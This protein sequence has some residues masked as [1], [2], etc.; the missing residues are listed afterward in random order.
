MTY[1]DNTLLSMAELNENLVRISNWNLE[2]NGKS[3]AKNLEFSD[4]KAAVF[5]VN[6]ISEI[7]EVEGHYPEIKIYDSNKIRI[8]LTTPS[9]EGLTKKDFDFALKIDG[10]KN[11]LATDSS[12]TA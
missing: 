7:T 11:P 3:I 9:V 6:K 12:E 5:F 2:D 10:L 1:S 8:K 4:F